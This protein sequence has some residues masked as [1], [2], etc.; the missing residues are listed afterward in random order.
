MKNFLFEDTIE[1]GFFFVRC[2]T[3][4]EAYEIISEEIGGL[5]HPGFI[6]DIH[7]AM[8]YYNYLGEYTDALAELMGYKIY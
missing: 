4:D 5:E 1:A 2:N 8:D 3:L 7:D 6:G